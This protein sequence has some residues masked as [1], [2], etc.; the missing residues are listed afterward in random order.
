MLFLFSTFVVM[1]RRPPRSTRTDTLFP[2]TTLFR[3]AVRRQI[4]VRVIGEARAARRRILVEPV[5]AI[6]ARDVDMAG[7][8]IAVVA[9]HLLHDL[10]RRVEA[11]TVGDVLRGPGDI[12]RQR[13]EAPRHVIA[14]RRRLT[15]TPRLRQIGRA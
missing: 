6:I 10:R 1:I 4:A 14:E 13:I 2:Y 15:V 7:P 12:V 3:S 5:R 11:V 9:A 8:R